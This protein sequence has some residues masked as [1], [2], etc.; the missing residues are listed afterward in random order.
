MRQ[1]RV[2]AFLAG[3]FNRVALEFVSRTWREDWAR[4]G[5]NYPS[6]ER[7]HSCQQ[8]YDASLVD[9]TGGFLM[10]L[11]CKSAYHVDITAKPATHEAAGSM[12]ATLCSGGAW[13]SSY[14]RA[15]AVSEVPK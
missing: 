13:S 3:S 14:G 2:R 11:R 10:F 15:G 7:I 9:K 6:W 8:R 12:R 5:Q 4:L 1:P